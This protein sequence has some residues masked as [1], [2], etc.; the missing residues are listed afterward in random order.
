MGPRRADSIGTCL[1]RDL[2]ASGGWFDLWGD[3]HESDMERS[4]DELGWPPLRF[5]IIAGSYGKVSGGYDGNDGN[6]GTKG[7]YKSA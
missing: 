6:A 1:L 7:N 2:K 5:S 3:S 4:A